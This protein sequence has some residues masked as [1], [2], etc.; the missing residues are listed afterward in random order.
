MFQ[1]LECGPFAVPLDASTV[2]IKGRWSISANWSLADAQ[3]V[4]NSGPGKFACQGFFEGVD[5]WADFVRPIVCEHEKKKAGFGDRTLAIGFGKAGG[6]TDLYER[7]PKTNGAMISPE[8]PRQPDVA[9][10]A[11][12]AA[13][14]SRK[15]L[16]K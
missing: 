2:V 7:T 9:E 8:P 1:K 12:K 3:L 15:R 5:G 14:A 11:M 16:Q 6:E 4:N 10:E 13:I